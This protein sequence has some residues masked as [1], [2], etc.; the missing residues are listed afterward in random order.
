MQQHWL[1]A[2]SRLAT[3]LCES[4]FFYILGGHF[5]V[6]A[7]RRRRCHLPGV[8]GQGHIL[9]YCADAK[10][11]A[12]LVPST[13]RRGATHK[14]ASSSGCGSWDG[15]LRVND[16]LTP[17]CALCH[18]CLL[19]NRTLPTRL[20]Q[21]ILL[22]A[23][24]RATRLVIGSIGQTQPRHTAAARQKQRSASH[25]ASLAAETML[26]RKS[27]VQPVLGLRSQGQ[28]SAAC[29]KARVVSMAW[30]LDGRRG[31]VGE[32]GGE[33]A[34]SGSGWWVR[35]IK[36]GERGRMGATRPTVGSTASPVKPA[37]G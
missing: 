24:M 19:P 13:W 37:W 27:C 4:V 22:C 26:R 28:Q 6:D 3:R 32:G 10:A 35:L 9:I 17:G 29:F 21:K 16:S 2:L 18:F 30:P 5:S 12:K 15:W 36:R 33:D 23:A 25:G 34:I 11:P 8:V 1:W 20:W 31:S 14:A 7:L